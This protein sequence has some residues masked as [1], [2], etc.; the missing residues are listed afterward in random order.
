VT[1]A[2]PAQFG[3]PSIKRHNPKTVRLNVGETYR[4]CLAIE[5]LR[6]ASLYKRIEG[7]SDAVV[8]CAD[9]STSNPASLR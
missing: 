4:G 7:W 6:A 3:R 2:D 9:A 8:A 5:V 1:Q